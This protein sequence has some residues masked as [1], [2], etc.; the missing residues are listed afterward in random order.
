MAHAVRFRTSGEQAD[1]PGNGP[2]KWDADLLHERVEEDVFGDGFTRVLAGEQT[3]SGEDDRDQEQQV[4]LIEDDID[5]RPDHFVGLYPTADE[6]N[7]DD[8]IAA[9]EDSVVFDAEWYVIEPHDCTHDREQGGPCEVYDGDELED[10]MIRRGD[11]PDSL[12]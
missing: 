9:F 8:F 12:S 3:D 1:N 4:R 6:E 11:V 10:K 5:N 7:I 2:A